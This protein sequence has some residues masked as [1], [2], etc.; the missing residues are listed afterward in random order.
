M[1]TDL[2]FSALL[3]FLFLLTLSADAAT[4]R[5][6]VR[7]TSGDV[8]PGA[9]VA[10]DAMRS[11]QTD[12]AGDYSFDVPA[13]TYTLAVRLDGFRDETRRVVTGE[14]AVITLTPALSETMVV[15]GIRAEESVPVTKTT[16]TRNEI[17]HRYAGQDI[18]MLLRDAPSM[19]SFAEAGNGGSGYSY[20]SLRGL[21]PTR[22]NFTLD[23]V[24]L[25]DSEDM[26]TYFADF[27]DLARSLESVQIQ[28]GV[29]TSTVGS[30]SFGGSVNFESIALSS[31][32]RLEADLG[33]GSF[34]NRQATVG[35]QSGALAG[36][37]S[38]YARGS[39]L[40]S[41]GFRDNSGIE[42]RNL[43]FS[44]SKQLKN[45]LLK[46][47][48]FS[49]VEAS[50]S[51]Y[52]AVDIDTLRANL[53]ANPL[54]REERDRFGYDLAQLQYIR[55]L[56]NGADMTASVYYQRGYG[57]Y[58]LFNSSRTTLRHY[59]L[60]GLL[61]GTMLSYSRTAGPLRM[62]YGLHLN[63]FKREHTRDSLDSAGA[64]TRNYAN[65]GVKGE[66]NA[67]VKATYDTGRM[68]LYGDAQLR[69]ADFAY[70][71]SVDIEPISWTFFNP[72]AGLRYD[73]SGRSSVYGSAGVST[74]EPARNDMFLGQDNPTI[75][76][77][78]HAV[79]P[80]RLLDI[81]G[82]W[83]YRRDALTLSANVYFMEF[84][85]EI[86]ATGEQS[87]IGL[88][89][90][91]NVDRSYRRG[92]E[93]DAAWQVTPE[94]R[95]R[96][97]GNFSRNRIAQWTQFYDVYDEAGELTGTKAVAFRDVEP[98]LTPAVVVNQ[99]I[100]YTPSPT[101]TVGAT[102]RWISRSYLDNTNAAALAAPSYFTLDMIASVAVA[103][104]LRMVVQLYN[105]LNN[106][107]IL[108]SGYSYL[109]T[110]REGGVDTP[111]GT[112]YYFPQATRHAVVLLQWRP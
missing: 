28:R 103:R 29:G 30:P 69:Y 6:T 77:D 34:G 85:N 72:K 79:R 66:T 83:D 110:T 51:A 70:H 107:R 57:W 65:Y 38:L 105:A 78:L 26:T 23:G 24:P 99:S 96:T 33:G 18:P 109:Y 93:L 90:R 37:Y 44:G 76:H 82:G 15:S 97:T 94:V 59:G 39:Y 81:E 86:A 2:R 7:S 13:G 25:S 60:D 10:L 54:S 104:D 36:G 21:S 32:A 22:L 61:A 67:F 42:Q 71:G 100:D 20:F 41:D 80:E 14:L 68:H 19:N 8:L 56:G 35:Y 31:T 43:F 45:A 11:A 64:G 55:D 9:T 101:L 74:R 108:P 87:E 106:D 46:L 4:L 12:A 102:G 62:Q 75:A 27:P 3:S 17:E 58:R 40:A 84:R 49:G 63:S 1:R 112:G 53:A 91:R 73:L 5:G 47:T 95:L 16:M 111:T 50:Q 89:L 98:L 88:T 48:G 92:I 52:Y